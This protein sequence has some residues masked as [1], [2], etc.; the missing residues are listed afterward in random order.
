MKAQLLQHQSKS[1]S[2][3]E[4]YQYLDFWGCDLICWKIKHTKTTEH[5]KTMTYTVTPSENHRRLDLYFMQQD[6]LLL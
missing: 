2:N 3:W 1:Y 4:K 6:E 5:N